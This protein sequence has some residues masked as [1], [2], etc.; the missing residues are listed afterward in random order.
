MKAKPKSQHAKLME[1]KTTSKVPKSATE[2]K[3]W[4][5]ARRK[6]VKSYGSQSEKSVPWGI[7][8]KIYANEKKAGK[9]MKESDITKS[10]KKK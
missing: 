10:K 3:Q 7:V 6:V 2:K 9:V 1:K 8:Q 5:Q 4:I